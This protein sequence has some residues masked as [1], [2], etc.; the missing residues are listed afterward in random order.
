MSHHST[1]LKE[2]PSGSSAGYLFIRSGVH[3]R[4][5]RDT[6]R[7]PP[8]YQYTVTGRV[9][10]RGTHGQLGTLVHINGHYVT[11]FRHEKLLYAINDKCSHMGAYDRL[12]SRG[13]RSRPRVGRGMAGPTL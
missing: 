6:A 5:L 11:I 2:T 7:F 9:R 1:P 13:A 10:K 3:V 8:Q 4:D 12:W